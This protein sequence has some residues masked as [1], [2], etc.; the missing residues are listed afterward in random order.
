MALHNYACTFAM[1]AW[2]DLRAILARLPARLFDGS[3]VVFMQTLAIGQF[4]PLLG[5]PG[6]LIAPLFIGTFTQIIFTAAYGISF[7]YVND[8]HKNKFINYQLTLPLP[9]AWVFAHI[10]LSF[11]IEFICISIPLVF[12]GSIFLGS[13]F[14]LIHARWPLV[15]CMYALTLVFYALLFV[16]L[17]FACPYTWFLDNIWARRLTPLFLLGCSYY[18]WKK[19]YAFNVPLAVI[20][21]A[22]PLTYVHEGLRGTLLEPSFFLSAWLCMGIIAGACALLIVLLTHAVRKRLD[23]V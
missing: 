8:L 6:Q 2:R 5:M 9:K 16:Y 15:F 11:I 22:N 19:L 20:L 7:R 23:P 12:L 3:I 17:A 4:L 13:S 21:L 1:L 14:S 10:V 18:T